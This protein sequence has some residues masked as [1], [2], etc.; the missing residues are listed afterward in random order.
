MENSPYI[1]STE[2]LGLRRWIEADY[3]SFIDMNKN[4]EV[5]KFF[6]KLL[7]P[8]ETMD[9]IKR[10]ETAMPP[11]LPAPTLFMVFRESTLTGFFLLRLY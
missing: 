11:K 9:F 1:I 10:I 5:L 7:T 6:P 8:D 3:A 2:R 4:K